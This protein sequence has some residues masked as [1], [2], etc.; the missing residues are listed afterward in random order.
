MRGMFERFAGRLAGGAPLTLRIG[1]ALL[2]LSNVGWKVPRRFG[3]SDD[4]C[5]GLCAFVN[6]GV[7]NG[8]TAPWRWLS[9]NLILPNL[10][11]FGWVTLITEFTLAA[12]LLSGRFTRAAASLGILHSIFIGLSV[13]NAPGEWYWSYALMALLHLA[14][15][16]SASRLAPKTSPALVAG[17]VI[18]YSVILGIANARSGLFPSGYTSEFLI[19]S[20]GNG[21][22]DDFGRNVFAGSIGLAILTGLAG[23]GGWRLWG[24]KPGR[25]LGG[26]LIVFGV[27]LLFLYRSSGNL[28]G[29]RPAPLA[30]IAALGLWLFFHTSTSR[31]PA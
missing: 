14:V 6:E 7:E 17:A 3:A 18:G 29:A 27:V 4:G 21:F 8:L 28:L 26:V 10:G 31:R 2:W 16:A 22:P 1:A 5:L 19:F 24:T 30:V 13:A 15:L 23:L 12:T 9:E 25:Y 11:I 20:G